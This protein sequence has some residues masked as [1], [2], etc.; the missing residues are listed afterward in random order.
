M[1]LN[2][3]I[4]SSPSHGMGNGSVSKPETRKGSNSTMTLGM[5]SRC[6]EAFVQQLVAKKSCF[7]DGNQSAC[8]FLTATVAGAVGTAVLSTKYL[9]DI[10]RVRSARMN[11]YASNASFEKLTTIYRTIVENEILVNRFE[12]LHEKATLKAQE[13]LYRELLGRDPVRLPSEMGPGR[14]YQGQKN[15]EYG[16]RLEAERVGFLQENQGRRPSPIPEKW[17]NLG[18]DHSSILYDET[19]NQLLDELDKNGEERL[20]KKYLEMGSKIGYTPLSLKAHL[21]SETLGRLQQAFPKELEEYDRHRESLEQQIKQKKGK[22][23][24]PADP[25]SQLRGE[26]NKLTNNFEQTLLK[27]NPKLLLI[28][29]LAE[30]HAFPE[31][32]RLANAFNAFDALKDIEQKGQ[33]PVKQGVHRSVGLALGGAAAADVVMTGVHAAA[34]DKLSTCAKTLG[35]TPDEV[36]LLNGHIS[37]L[38]ALGDCKNLRIDDEKT[39]LIAAQGRFGY[40]PRG[41]CEMALRENAKYDNLTRDQNI[42]SPTCNLVTGS[43]FQVETHESGEKEL[44]CTGKAGVVYKFPMDKNNFANFKDVR[45]FYQGQE[46]PLYAAK[47][48]DAYQVRK[49]LTAPSAGAVP[50]PT[51]EHFESCTRS[52]SSSDLCTCI[53]AAFTSQPAL[54][55]NAVTCDSEKGL[56]TPEVN[57]TDVIR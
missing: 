20:K 18:H 2:L 10:A 55:V 14:Y 35:L 23:P 47:F 50:D 25:N 46:T 9:A 4:F 21:R 49:A 8:I 31:G 5:D 3:S 32:R 26:I 37:N 40:V 43:S 57:A 11:S 1:V 15:D 56:S 28:G 34:A 52:S 7:K 48:N 39:V 6:N 27:N 22:F 24:Q 36:T 51:V 54:A 30:H 12:H 44:S 19:H 42:K 17:R 33:R 16:A 45:A 53:K 29:S 13:A 41:I 38:S